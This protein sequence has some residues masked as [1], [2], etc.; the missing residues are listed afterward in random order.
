[1]RT[2]HTST[3]SSACGDR[4]ATSDDTLQRHSDDINLS[5][6]ISQF[7]KQTHETKV[8]RILQVLGY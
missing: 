3:F 7:R 5:F 4:Q 1:M 2:Y 8:A 6:F